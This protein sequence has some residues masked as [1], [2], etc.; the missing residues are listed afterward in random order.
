MRDQR[1]A[2]DDAIEPN[3]HESCHQL[4]LNKHTDTLKQIDIQ[5]NG[6]V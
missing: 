3:V 5:I 1:Y 4:F 2:A 6:D